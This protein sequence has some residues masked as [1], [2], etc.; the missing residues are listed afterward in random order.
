[1]KRRWGRRAVAAAAVLLVLLALAALG[2]LGILPGVNG[3]YRSSTPA[4]AAAYRAKET[5]SCV[6]VQGRDEA[7]CRAWTV[8]SPDLARAEVDRAARLVRA[9]ALGRWSA[10]AR[11]VDARR[12][13]VLE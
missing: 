2:A 7:Y 10:R 3:R 12:G 6:F 9:R 1:M 13:C 11:Y 8:A 4:L 5:C